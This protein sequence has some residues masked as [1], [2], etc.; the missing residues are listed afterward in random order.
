MAFYQEDAPFQF[1][2][3]KRLFGSFLPASASTTPGGWR[4]RHHRWALSSSFW[5]LIGPLFSLGISENFFT[6]WRII[7]HSPTRY[8]KI[9]M[10]AFIVEKLYSAF[11][12]I[13]RSLRFGDIRIVFVD[14][15]V[16]RW[17]VAQVF[18]RTIFVRSYLLWRSYRDDLV[19]ILSHELVHVE[20]WRRYGPLFPALYLISS[21]LS[22]VRGG[23]Y[24]WDNKFER[25]AREKKLMFVRQA[26]KISSLL[27]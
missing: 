2:L 27:D 21:L 6:K 13:S 17:A 25:E 4:V 10:L 18:G 19:E 22:W 7:I 24:Y 8:T 5:A 3:T 16:P 14:G 11:Y 26:I 1:S 20:Q 9:T 12:G 23:H 15:M